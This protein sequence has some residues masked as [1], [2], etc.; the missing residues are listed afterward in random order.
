M[1]RRYVDDTFVVQ[2]KSHNEE[3]FQHI[4]TV[5]TSIKFTVEEGRPDGSIP[6]L[7]ILRHGTFT[8]KVYRKPT[9]TDQYLQWD[10]NHNLTSKYSVINTLTHKTRTLCSTPELINNELKRLEEV[11]R[12]CKYPRW[13]IKKILQKQQHQQDKTN[14][15][16]HN[17]S[18]IKKR[19][20]IVVL[21]SQ[22]ISES[23]KNICHRYGNTSTFQRRSNH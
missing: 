6:C 2:Q 23:L 12:S 17:K 20:H 16:R 19:C 9:H 8:T 21:Y 7:D 15:K 13:A 11:L 10:S 18:S 4:N 5:D 3:F 14:R 22:G 1:W